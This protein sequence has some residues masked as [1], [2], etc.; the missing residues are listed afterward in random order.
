MKKFEKPA[1]EVITFSNDVIATSGGCS[2]ECYSV[3][4]GQCRQVS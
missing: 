3:C 1:M 4:M 2:G